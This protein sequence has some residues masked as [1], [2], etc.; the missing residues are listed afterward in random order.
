M[1]RN[2]RLLTLSIIPITIF[3][4]AYC[5]P[6]QLLL[7]IPAYLVVQFL[8]SNVITPQVVRAQLNIPAG[9]L[10]LF[11]LLITFAL[12]ALGL[13]LAVPI[14]ACLIVL[15]REVYSYDM[16]K[17]KYIEVNLD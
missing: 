12:G 5:Q 16:L 9:F 3:T 10:M 11:Q 7:Y 13:V 17:L 1:N 14:L 6:F 2:L 8:E 4:L 15:V